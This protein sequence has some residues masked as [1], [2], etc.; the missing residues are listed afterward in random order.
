MTV[1]TLTWIHIHRPYAHPHYRCPQPL[2]CNT[3]T[4]DTC[5]CHL[6][7]TCLYVLTWQGPRLWMARYVTVEN[8]P[9]ESWGPARSGGELV[10][11]FTIRC[12]GG[13]VD[14]TTWPVQP[15]QAI[16]VWFNKSSDPDIGTWDAGYLSNDSSVAAAATADV[17]KKSSA[18]SATGK[19]FFAMWSELWSWSSRATRWSRRRRCKIVGGVACCCRWRCRV[20]RNALV[21]SNAHRRTPHP[22]FYDCTG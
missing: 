12:K 18:S 17:A 20:V 3:I 21:P 16:D 6:S 15:G 14:A 9:P 19:M 2:T 1:D 10:A 22:I 5:V 8:R 11:T 4:F 13:R 7:V